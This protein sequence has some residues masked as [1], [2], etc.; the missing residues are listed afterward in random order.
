MLRISTGRFEGVVH[1]VEPI[2]FV[3]MSL[4]FSYKFETGRFCILPLPVTK[5][6]LAL[7]L[8]SIILLYLLR[9]EYPCGSLCSPLIRRHSCTFEEKYGRT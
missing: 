4:V 1:Y 5:I 3:L 7:K 8:Y 6:E 2:Y 9:F